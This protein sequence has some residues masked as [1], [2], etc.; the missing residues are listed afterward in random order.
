M[1]AAGNEPAGD[2]VSYCN[3][4]VK[5]MHQYDSTRVY[6]GAS[7]GGGWAWDDGSQYH[8]K[9]GARGL[10]WD[11]RAPHSDDDYYDQIEY[12]RYYAQKLGI[13]PAKIVCV[14]VMPCTAKKFE[15]TSTYRVCCM[16]SNFS[17]AVK[18]YVFA[19]IITSCETVD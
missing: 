4:W 15:V 19:I 12:P 5:Q 14:G 16:R 11:K 2:W 13:D 6:C 8:V 9:G 17:S 1:M 18:P 3:D 10:D 7:V